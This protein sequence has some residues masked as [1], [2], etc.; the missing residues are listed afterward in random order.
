MPQKR[1]GP[2]GL[3]WLGSFD[4]RS[5]LK[6]AA[7][8]TVLLGAS[9]AA[10]A[11]AAPGAHALP[12]LPGLENLAS[13]RIR[14][15]FRDLYSP[16]ATQNEWGYV[17]AS[18]SVTGITALSF[19]PYACCGIPDTA[20]SPGYLS[21]CELYLNGELLE[22]SATSGGGTSYIW[23]P[24]R[25]VRQAQAEGVAITTTT[26]MP[27]KRR[28]LLQSIVVKNLSSRRKT[29]TLGF[30]LRAAVTKKSGTW[31]ANSPGE[32]DNR[33][34]W[35]A[36][37]SC[38]IFEAQHSQAA[39]V[40]GFFPKADRMENKR[41]LIFEITLEPGASREFHYANAIAGE[42]TEA[43][44]SYD[45]LQA[46]FPALLQQN[47][48]V[49]AGLVKAAF[50]PGNSAFSGHLPQLVTEDESLWNLY[51]RGFT[52]LLFGRR[53]SPDSAYGLTYLTLGGRVLPTLS[54]PWDT[55]LTSLS[56]AM[57]DPEP[58][59]RLIETWFV[60]DMHQ[61][62]ATDYVS[63]EAI[64]PWYAVNDMAILRC[65]Q[66]YLRVT[67]NFAWLDRPVDG[68]PVLE[69][70]ADH[71]R[72]WKKLDHYGRGLGD[73]GKIENLLEVVSTYLHEV[74][75]MNAGNVSGMRFVAALLERK[76]DD[77]R[78][79]QLRAEADALAARINR[80]L[81][82]QGKGYWRCGQPDG[83]YNEVRHCYDL[84]SV[85]DNME[86]DLSAEQKREMNR[87]FWSELHN[88]VWMRALSAGDADATWN[89]RP[90]HSSI[91]A[92]PSWP[93]MT[94][95]ALLRIDSSPELASQLAAWIK[96]LGRAGNQGPFGQAHFVEPV[97]PPEQGGARKAPEDAPY[98]NDWCCIAAGSF[99]D[100]VIDSI[101][102]ADLR[103]HDGIRV[104]SRLEHFDPRARLVNLPYQGKNF[105]ISRNG[106]EPDQ[107]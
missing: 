53:D 59:R 100:M 101:F 87:F 27:S 68:K 3:N 98:L 94:A 39:S 10:N 31:F 62:L 92:Y 5:F 17:K 52:N 42:K 88:P 76:G 66:N 107:G 83:S 13:D 63:G 9:D 35:D 28:A 89:I 60:Q 14:N 95:K 86:Q 15:H 23:Y 1:Q 12:P 20:W 67:G 84:L 8:S 32:A 41:V 26:C 85:F 51:Y 74:A 99:V 7:A 24:H 25:I 77:T 81:Y 75:G 56:L 71:A 70:L 50:T 2:S 38:L 90:D 57:L 64:G 91:G 73:Y 47:E 36:T 96:Q 44:T 54:F 6:G 49:F 104:T 102:G 40:Q 19:P 58:L 33:I 69:H 22:V 37:R 106:V 61:H 46:D 105:S 11:M 72:Y 65:A 29:L 18:K 48:D 55:S 16:P 103:L 80:L 82:V 45:R 30:D 34:A 21:T 79:R 97:F 43:L 78:A 4:R 93:P